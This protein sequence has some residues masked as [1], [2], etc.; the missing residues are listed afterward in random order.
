MIPLETLRMALASLRGHPLRTF[1]TLLGVI[2]GVTTVVTVVSIISGLN[3]YIEDKV[4]TLGADAFVVDR[5]GIITSREELI[6]AFKRRDITYDDLQSIRR[7]CTECVLVGA[8]V[9]AT[10]GVTYEA[11]RLPDT[12]V[13]GSTANANEA[14]NLEVVDG[15]FYTDSE[16]SSAR[17][18]AVI[19]HDV[20]SEL[21]GDLA[22][23]GRVLKVGGYPFKVI[24]VLAKRGSVLGQNQDKVVYLP[25][26][27]WQ[28]VFGARRSLN[29]LVK[30][31]GKE[32]MEAAQEQVRQIMRA[33]RHTPYDDPDPF[34]IITA[35][36]LD[37]IWR[38]ISAGAFALMTAISGISLAVGGIVIMNIMLVS[39]AERTQEIGLRRALGARR[40]AIRLQFLTEAV[41]LSAAGGLIG[42]LI[43]WVVGMGVQQASPLPVSLKPSLV[44]VSLLVATLVGVAS[45]IFP[46]IQASN[47]QPTEAL[48]SE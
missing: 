38:G 9:T 12:P 25:I 42:L 30:A 29:V 31:G 11:S 7:F 8:D 22:A 21:F 2:I 10:R 3:A 16:V 46:S 45:G 6:Q 4:L 17:P 41:L 39:V 20:R 15:R 37:S 5:F 24:G 32:G 48:R 1:L 19:G 33:R 14:Q 47:L 34:A 40:S 35:S 43:G 27:S 18:V 28:K 26:T 13:H 44:L 23:T 36:A